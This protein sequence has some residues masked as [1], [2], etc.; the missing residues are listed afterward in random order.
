MKTTQCFLTVLG[1]CI[2]CLI[3]TSV[4]TAQARQPVQKNQ[5]GKTADTEKR[6]NAQDASDK[7]A[8]ARADADKRNVPDKNNPKKAIAT[9]SGADK[10][11]S[12]TATNKLA[13]ADKTKKQIPSD[14]QKQKETARETVID[15]RQ[16]NQTK[17]IEHGVQ[18]GYLTPVEI[19][20]LQ[21]QQASIANLEKSLKADGRLS[22]SDFKKMQ[23]ALNEASRNIWGE[24]HDTDG[25]QMATF[26]LGQNV[27][28]KTEFANK[29]ADANLKPAEA[30]KMLSDFHAIME[31]KKRLATEDLPDGLRKKLQ[32]EYNDL[33][34]RYF[35]MRNA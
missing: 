10:E 35:E 17:R 26:R 27:F 7:R 9:N 25:K 4:L 33:L 20:K 2:T 3:G 28:A 23:D 11:K 8:A 18:K 5:P 30:K 22:H 1:V 19:K 32:D 16:G 6:A 21:D 13:G 31:I 34:N 15:N 24:K 12:S 29:M 14:I